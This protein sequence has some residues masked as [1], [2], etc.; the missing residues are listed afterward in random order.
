MWR[1]I[2]GFSAGLYI[3]TYYECK[4]LISR[5]ISDIKKNLPKEK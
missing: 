1:F 5:I 4:P 3:G 2:A